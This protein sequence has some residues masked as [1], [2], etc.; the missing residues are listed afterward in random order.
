M[1][2]KAASVCCTEKQL[3]ILNKFLLSTTAPIRIVQRAR[4]ILLAFDKMRNR[5]IAAEVGLHV[6]QV[7]LWRRRWQASFDAL[8]AIECRESTAVLTRSI[9]QVLTDAPRSGSPGTFTAEQVTQILATA[10]EPPSNSDRP[11]DRW[12][13]REL[14]DEV[15]K[16]KIVDS[17]SVRQVGRYLE[18]ADLQPHRSKLWLNSKEKDP[19]VFQQQV[20]TVCQT[21]LDAPDLYFQENTY[22]VS[23]DEMPGIQAVERIAKDIPMQP[24]QPI[25]REYEYKRHGTLCLI[26][27][28]DVVNGQMLAPTISF[29]RT[30]QDLLEHFKQLVRTDPNAGWVIVLDNLNVHCSESLVRWIA[31][32]EGMDES[33]LGCKGKSGILKS[34][35]SRREFLEDLTHRIR[36]VFTPKHSSWLNQIEI[37]FGIVHRRAIARGSFPSLTALKERLLDFI[38][39][40]NRTF[41]RPFRWTYTGRPVK[42]QAPPR[43]RTW[44]ENWASWRHTTQTS[45]S[46]QG[47]L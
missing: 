6:D 31:S 28:W 15:I 10:C 47:E 4:I 25:R 34:V 17:I 45:P 2:G 44:R 24:G 14:T 42:A 32:L 37:V 1:P 30:E 22:T 39:Y 3:A 7:G 35:A 41:A 40:F 29:T 12:T 36:F 8:V 11:I 18:E 9:E 19:E 20:E 26:G 33:E 5:D 23:V 38:D 46:I 16:R 43:P 21:Y 27:N 13:N